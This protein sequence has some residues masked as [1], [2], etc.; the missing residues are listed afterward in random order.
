[1]T[2]FLPS[3]PN[4]Y[5][6]AATRYGDDA[7]QTA[8]PQRLLVLLYDRLSLDLQRAHQAQLDGHREAAHLNLAHAQDIVAE[9]L[10][11]L[12]VDAWAGATDLS[13]LYTWL[14]AELTR[15]NVRMDA[16][17]TAGCLEVVEPLREAW[18]AAAASAGT[19]TGVPAMGL[20]G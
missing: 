12:D 14:L 3:Q 8:S 7:V 6:R 1:M 18:T 5:A 2:T 15:A 16:A 13:R 20:T 9:L 19:A 11:S 17:L 10:S 4:A